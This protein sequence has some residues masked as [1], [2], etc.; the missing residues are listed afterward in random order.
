MTL[1]KIIKIIKINNYYKILYKINSWRGPIWIN[2]NYLALRGIKLYY[3]KSTRAR[4]IYERYRLKLI[5][6][7]CN[8][9]D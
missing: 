2:I 4:K 3:Y 9:F 6:N 8:N 1:T 5:S 7:V